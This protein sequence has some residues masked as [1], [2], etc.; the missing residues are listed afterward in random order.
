MNFASKNGIVVKD[1][2][3]DEMENNST[4]LIFKCTYSSHI[5]STSHS[6]TLL[7]KNQEILLSFHILNFYI[8]SYGYRLFQH[9]WNMF[10]SFRG[11][12]QAKWI[13]LA[14]QISWKYGKTL[15]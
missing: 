2:T 1:V 3:N 9:A 11:R 4:N 8:S 10:R 13:L 5:G 12:K 15:G 14:L 6:L 7:F